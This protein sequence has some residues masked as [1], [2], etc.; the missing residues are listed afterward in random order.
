M[1]DHR[2]IRRALRHTLILGVVAALMSPT[3]ALAKSDDPRTR[4][5]RDPRA[6]G[7]TIH[8]SGHVRAAV[9]EGKHGL[10]TIYAVQT[11]TGRFVGLHLAKGQYITPNS[12]FS[13]DIAADTSVAGRVASA[14][15]TALDDSQ[16]S[17]RTHAHHLHRH[18]QRHWHFPRRQR[19]HD[20]RRE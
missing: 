8:V 12:T 1:L 11:K 13:G 14:T 3:A 5:L 20:V 19:H 6:I 9:V 18:A 10:E 2:A 4:T 16:F 17:V 7:R 15:I